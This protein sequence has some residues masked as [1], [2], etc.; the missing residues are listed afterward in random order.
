MLCSKCA[1]RRKLLALKAQKLSVPVKG[2]WKKL[3][4]MKGKSK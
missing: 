4:N 1:A 2:A 3:V